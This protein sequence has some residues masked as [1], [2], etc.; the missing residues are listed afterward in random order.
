MAEFGGPADLCPTNVSATSSGRGQTAGPGVDGVVLDIGV[1]SMQLDE[2]GARVFVPARRSARHAHVAARPL[3]CRCRQLRW[4]RKISPTFSLDLGEERRSRA[5]ARTI[6]KARGDAPIT[7]T[8]ALPD[9]SSRVLG[10]GARR[11]EAFGDA[12]VPGAAHLRQRRA[13]RARAR[14]RGGRAHPEARRAARRRHLPLARG[15]DREAVPGHAGPQGRRHIAL[16][17]T[18][19]EGPRARQVSELLTLADLHLLKVNLT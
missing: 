16:S 17:A 11:R 19:A 1:S 10:A 12:H 4:T 3:R 18:A 2:P 14:S 15:P 9:S 5:I 7:T 6:V 13:R 8:Q